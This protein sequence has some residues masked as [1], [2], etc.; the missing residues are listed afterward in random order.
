MDKLGA[1][2]TR[3]FLRIFRQ[4]G[5]RFNPGENVGMTDTDGRNIIRRIGRYRDEMKRYRSRI[6][7]SNNQMNSSFDT[8]A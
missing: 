5:N 7:E 4:I 2:L 8:N 6:A 1:F 3:N